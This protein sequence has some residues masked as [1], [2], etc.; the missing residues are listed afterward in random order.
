MVAWGKGLREIEWKGYMAT[1]RGVME[2]FFVLISVVYMIYTFVQTHR[3]VHLKWVH[4]IICKLYFNKT[5]RGEINK[6][7]GVSPNSCDRLIPF[8]HLNSQK[9]P[10]LISCVPGIIF[11]LRPYSPENSLP[12]SNL[13]SPCYHHYSWPWIILESRI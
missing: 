13:A 4:F 8:T 5:W 2:V 1:L 12:V 3:T 9:T 10:T 6:P 11:A 7:G